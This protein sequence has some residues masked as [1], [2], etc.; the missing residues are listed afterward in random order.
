MKE[1]RPGSA[2]TS[3]IRIL[4][5]FDPLRRAVLLVV[6][7]KSGNWHRWYETAIPVADERYD[8][9]LTE[10]ERRGYR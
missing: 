8:L 4:F 9:H 3:E 1:L 7:D 5:A 10:I 6:G 2:G